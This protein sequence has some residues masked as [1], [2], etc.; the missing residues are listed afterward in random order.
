[1]SLIKGQSKSF[2]A[3]NSLWGVI[4]TLEDLGVI[5]RHSMDLVIDKL[6]TKH[7]GNYEQV[8]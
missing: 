4:F 7:W 1:M 5:S 2:A 3:E 8:Q 6:F